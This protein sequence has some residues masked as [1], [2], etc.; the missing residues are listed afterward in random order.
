MRDLAASKTILASRVDGPAGA[1]GSGTSQSQGLSA[2]GHFVAFTSDS[3]LIAGE[4]LQ[5]DATEVYRRDLTSGSTQLVSR[6]QGPNG[7]AE[8]SDARF[9]GGISATGACVAFRA[10]GDLLGP[11]PGA[12]DYTQNFMRVFK[13][14]C[15]PA[16]VRASGLGGRD[17]TAPLLRSVSLT[18][19]RFRVAKASTPLAA[20][21]KARRKAI[22]AARCCASRAARPAS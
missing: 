21:A 15:D 17:A 18:H 14:D 2:D 20:G 6:G 12:S 16:A 9:A 13:A 7:T 8:R 3:N 10:G 22:A 11:A 19:T 5:T 4:G 1:A